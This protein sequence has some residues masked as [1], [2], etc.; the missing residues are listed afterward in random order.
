VK[1]TYSRE[2]LLQSH[3]YVR[4]HLVGEHPMH[5]GFDSNGIYRTPRTL[6]RWPAI[7]AWRR[8]LEDRGGTLIDVSSSLLED[9]TYPN[10][11]QQE[12]LLRQGFGQILW[13]ALT[14]TGRNEARAAVLT[15]MSAPDFAQVVTGDLT[16]M[17]TGHLNNG[18]LEAHGMDE[19]GDPATPHLGAHDAMWLAA[20]DLVFGAA[21]YPPPTPLEGTFKP[22]R[23]EMPRIPLEHEHF[24]KFMMNVLM[25][26][27]RSQAFF[28]YCLVLF[29][30]PRNFPGRVDEARQA[31][32]IVSRIATDEIVHIEYL[33]LLFSELR[34]MAF[35]TTDGGEAPGEEIID[36]LWT[37]IVD[38]HAADQR[39]FASVRRDDV[40]RQVTNGAGA[41]ATSLMAQFDR[42]ADAVT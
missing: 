17:L 20:R 35:R 26:E 30:D 18:L 21:A 29:D 39:R 14:L 3:R 42:L 28:D 5:G 37:R 38:W 15:S 9:D 41:A 10:V 25:L 31:A 11:S 12:L 16:Q 33:R 4:P 13:N 23:R 8:S 22:V 1:L 34:F 27:V 6:N 40:E 32:S 36:P 24:L 19:A 7:E 2:E